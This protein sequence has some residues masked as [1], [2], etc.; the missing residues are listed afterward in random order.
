MKPK[1]LSQAADEVLRVERHWL[2]RLQVA[3]AQF[4]ATDEDRAV[5]DR[6]IRQLD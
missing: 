5:L 1:I 3:L 4:P 2:S 6:S